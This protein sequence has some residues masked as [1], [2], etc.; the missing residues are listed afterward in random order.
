MKT[1]FSLL[2]FAFF[3]RTPCTAAPGGFARVHARD[4]HDDPAG[5]VL[6]ARADAERGGA[7]D[8]ESSVSHS[9]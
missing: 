3:K 5:E 9:A 6:G 4:G 1:R 8:V 2:T 7:V